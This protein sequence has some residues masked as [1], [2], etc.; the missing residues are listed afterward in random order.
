MVT[1]ESYKENSNGRIY[2]NAFRRLGHEVC[3]FYD[4][5]EM[6]KQ[7]ILFKFPIFKRVNSWRLQ[8]KNYWGILQKGI[9]S[10]FK[11]F[12]GGLM[13]KILIIVF[14]Y[15]IAILAQIPDP[16]YNPMTA[17]GAIG[18]DSSEHKLFWESPSNVLYNECY[19]SND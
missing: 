18:I 4:I 15:S 19:F 14:V 12:M 5:V 9:V 7:S 3:E 16:A 6:E 2:A 17:P 10:I 1:C 11:I 13:K 8:E